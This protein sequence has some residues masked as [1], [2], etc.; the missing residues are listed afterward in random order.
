[1]QEPKDYLKDKINETERKRK[2]KNFKDINEF[3][4]GFEERT[5]LVKD[6]NGNLVDSHTFKRWKNY[7]CQLLNVHGVMMLGK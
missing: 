6:W 3:K 5:D 7:L 2:A 1:L 4:K